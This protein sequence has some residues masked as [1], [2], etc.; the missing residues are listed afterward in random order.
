MQTYTLPGVELFVVDIEIDGKAGRFGV[1]SLNNVDIQVKPELSESSILLKD[2]L[3]G[4]HVDLYR[5]ATIFVPNEETA[6]RYRD[7][8]T[9]MKS[10]PEGVYY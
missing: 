3:F 9:A 6:K 10:S 5:S 8:L 2:Q 7:W 1:D 4:F